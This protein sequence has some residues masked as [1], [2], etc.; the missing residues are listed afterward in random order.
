MNHELR[1]QSAHTCWRVLYTG[2]S[3]AWASTKW[4]AT[5]TPV[6][7][8]STFA[9]YSCGSWQA[10]RI[11]DV[12]VV[13]FP[14]SAQNVLAIF[15][16]FNINIGGLG[17]PLSCISLGEYW[18]KMLFTILFPI[19]I[20]ACILFGS[21]VF[22]AWSVARRGASARYSAVH[23]WM[24]VLNA[25]GLLALPH[26][27]MLS[28]LV[29]PMVSSTAFQAFACEPFDNGEAFL[30]AD[31]AVR[32]YTP[33]HNTARGL[34]MLGLLLYPIG[35]SLLYIILFRKANRAILDEKPTAL[36]RALGFLTLDFEK[37]W[38]GWELIEAWK[39]CGMW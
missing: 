1:P 18:Q 10:T 6:A 5:P 37:A 36:S 16:V 15:E 35:V 24:G 13:P 20:G 11:P 28:F 8:A 30:R 9:H 32:C 23:T 22:A 26:L 2:S 12:Y 3:S 7:L 4:Y 33:A 29:F 34:A 19:S 27:L 14:K 17:L 39:K 38:F 31:F 25:G 21:S